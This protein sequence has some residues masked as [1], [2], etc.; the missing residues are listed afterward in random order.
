MNRVELPQ[1]YK[2]IRTVD[3]VKDKKL[4]L[5]VNL[6]AF[7]IMIIMVVLGFIIRPLT[8]EGILSIQPTDP[9]ILIVGLFAYIILHELTHGVFM[10]HFSGVK[11]KYGYKLVYAYA[12]ST[13]YFDKRSYIIIALAP[14]VIW[15][16]VLLA[17]NLLLPRLF[18]VIY[19]IQMMNISGAAGDLYVTWLMNKLPDDILINDTGVAMTVYS[20]KA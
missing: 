5:L 20:A 11:P 16:I 2:L 19:I 17:L 18:W 1:D 6:A 8:A 3:L 9:I 12:G 4:M 15:G 7:A 13:A 14:I 10:K